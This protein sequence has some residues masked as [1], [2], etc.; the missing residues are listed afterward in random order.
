MKN[1]PR[2]TSALA[3]L[4]AGLVLLAQPGAL[5]AKPA[6]PAEAAASPR[7]RLIVLTDIGNEP[8][9]SESMVRLLTYANDIDIEGL[10]ASTSRHL[11]DAVHPEMIERRVAAYG[12]VVGNLRVHDPRYPEAA[13]LRALIRPGLPAE[14][15]RAVGEGK[16]SEASRLIIAAVDKPDPRPLWISVWGGAAPLAQA[17]WHVQATRSPAE[18][19]RFVAKLRVY[20]ISDQDDSGPW[21]RATFPQLFWIASI[22]G[23]T[24]YE[25]AAWTGISAPLP[26]ADQTMVD[27]KWLRANIQQ[28]GALGALYPTPMFIMEGDTPSFLNLVGNGLSLPERPDWGGWGGRWEQP[29]PQFGHW[30]DTLD[31]VTGTD[32]KDYRTNKATI[33]R[34]R[35]AFQADFAARMAWSVTPNRADANHPPSLVANGSAGTAPLLITACPGEPVA[36]SAAG[37]S[38]PDRQPLSLRWW[39]Y[40]EP[41][42]LWSPDLKL[43]SANGE[44][45]IATVPQWSQPH[46]AAMPAS[47]SFHV[48]LEGRDSGT[49]ALTRY[50]RVVIE[51]P[52][53]GRKVNG[54]A[55][56][57][58]NYSPTPADIDYDAAPAAPEGV[59]STASEIGDLLD[60]PQ[61][62]AI[63]ERLAPEIIEATKSHAQVLGFTINLMRSLDPR[64]TA[65][66]AAAIDAELRK[67]P[68]E[69]APAAH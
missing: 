54:K 23:P 12:Q 53:D 22:H 38:D 4:S 6:Q 59:Y 11:P 31:T 24:Q 48:V 16:D 67:V 50:R 27:R 28:R 39:H 63:I 25:L 42:G 60:H 61:T 44:Q 37:S 26:G 58:I 36:L 1:P 62:R 51:V 40:R 9:D 21:A 55:C 49:P 2:I 18:V 10:V 66:R 34:W 65:A 8:D 47:F 68:I 45:T 19:A 15:M 57:R 43:S 33:W 56:P 29:S 5:A 52:T 69:D 30:A 41:S 35:E 7:A 13:A 3:G 64:M 17:L 46:M 32:G 20:S 14:G